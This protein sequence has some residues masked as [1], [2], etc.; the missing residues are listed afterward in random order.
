[1]A[2]ARGGAGG[3]SRPPTGTIPHAAILIAGDTL[4]VAQVYDALMPPDEPRTVLVDT[5][6]DEAEEALRVAAALGPR[7]QSVRLDTPAERGRVT[8]GLVREV[9][10]RLDQAG[11]G[12]V[13]IFVSG[14]LTPDRIPPLAEAGADGFGVGSYIAAAP[15]IDMTM[16][17]KVVAGRPVAKRGRIPGPTPAPR[18][19]A[20]A[21]GVQGKGDDEQDGSDR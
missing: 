20:V 5:F 15:P 6:H 3:P 7:L 13:R 2:F 12:H 19:R 14:G 16:D 11:F 10:A 1:G 4:R 18:L 9:R 8:P 21:G 17:L